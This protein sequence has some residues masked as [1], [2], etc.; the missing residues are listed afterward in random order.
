MIG[1]WLDG[2]VQDFM[3]WEFYSKSLWILFMDNF[4]ANLKEVNSDI[5]P[6]G[7]AY[8]SGWFSNYVCPCG[9]WFGSD[10]IAKAREHFNRGHY[11]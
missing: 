11:D 9:E 6:F 8:L 4:A 1:M 10:G 3:M 5:P 7:A 2:Y